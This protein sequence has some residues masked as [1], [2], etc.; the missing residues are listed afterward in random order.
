[1]FTYGAP[2]AL[3]FH[4]PATADAA[5]SYI[6]A[7]YAMLAAESLGLGSCLLGSP[8]AL[9][10]NPQFKAKYGIPKSNKIALAMPFGHPAAEFRR[11]VRRRLGDVRFA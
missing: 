8:V 1:Y 10:Y 5:D 3:L 4:H 7:T 2:A 9:N 11:G 6:A